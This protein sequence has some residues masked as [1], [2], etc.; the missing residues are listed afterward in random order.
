MPPLPWTLVTDARQPFTDTDHAVVEFDRGANR[1]HRWDAIYS[2]LHITPGQAAVY[3]DFDDIASADNTDLYPLLRARALPVGLSVP[4][5]Y[6]GT[7]GHLTLA[8]IQAFVT[9]LGTEVICHS[10]THTVGTSPTDWP[11]ILDEIITAGA[12]LEALGF[13]VDSFNQP[14]NWLNE[15]YWD[16]ESKFDT[17]I[18]A[19]LM[20]RYVA[21]YAYCYSGIPGDIKPT[22]ARFRHGAGLGMDLAATST[23]VA[24]VTANLRKA[25]AMNGTVG[26]YA[27]TAQ[28]GTAGKNTLATVTNILDLLVTER[29][30]GRIEVFNPTSALHVTPSPIGRLNIMDDGDFHL[31]DSSLVGWSTLGS[32]SDPV[33]N[34]AAGPNGA[35]SVTL[36]AS[37]KGLLHYL[38]LGQRGTMIQFQARN[39]TAGLTGDAHLV[40]DYFDTGNSKQQEIDVR[41]SAGTAIGW[42]GLTD[43]W[44]T[45]RICSAPLKTASP[46]N[47]QLQFYPLSGGANP[48]EIADVRVVKL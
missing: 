47:I 36:S 21:S 7:G 6:I 29:A 3:L 14:G 4:T 43:V 10:R 5:S 32:G 34:V 33:V 24:S 26:L 31:D 16:A 17:A 9:N 44:Q 19:L 1:R 20:S 15:L 12:D 48:V 27:H 37:N 42:G 13:N 18:G 8:Q 23:T 28:I 45:Y 46:N 40:L 35:N 11:T 2:G 38:P 39:A 25:Q 30:A 41:T 22:P